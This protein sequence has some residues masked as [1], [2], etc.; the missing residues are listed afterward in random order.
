M[1]GFQ[2]KNGGNLIENKSKSISIRIDVNTF[3]ALKQSSI[4]KGKSISATIQALLIKYFQAPEKN[5]P[6]SDDP[7]S[8]GDPLL[9]MHKICT[10]KS[11]SLSIRS[12]LL[13]ELAQY[14]HPKMRRIEGQ[15]DFVSDITYEKKLELCL[16]EFQAKQ[17][18]KPEAKPEQAATATQ[19]EAKPE[20]AA[21]ATQPEAKPEAT[22]IA[23]ASRGEPI[24]SFQ[25]YFS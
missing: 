8:L 22:Q 10:D 24:K 2:S 1:L 11:I 9:E 16:E 14:L 20:Q 12:K 23:I 25:D 21:T 18:A 13:M 19:P 4:D 15:S 5:L 6:P 17:A 3:N 7:A